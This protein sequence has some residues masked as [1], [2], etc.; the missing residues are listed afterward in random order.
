[1]WRSTQ[2]VEP[3]DKTLVLARMWDIYTA[4]TSTPFIQDENKVSGT[5]LSQNSTKMR[6]T[7]TMAT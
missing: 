3:E 4:A 6:H 2:T 1:M 7:G 5:F